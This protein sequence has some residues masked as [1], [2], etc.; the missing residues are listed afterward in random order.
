MLLLA[1]GVLSHS[2]KHGLYEFA[3]Y[4]QRNQLRGSTRSIWALDNR[5]LIS[6]RLA[7]N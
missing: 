7:C 1:E 4:T 5:P 6:F 2:G 3:I